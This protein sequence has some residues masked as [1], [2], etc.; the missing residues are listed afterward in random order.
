MLDYPCE[1][2]ISTRVLI[3]GK[4]EIGISSRRCD[5]GNKMLE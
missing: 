1:P 2:S 4:Q 3:G 5:D